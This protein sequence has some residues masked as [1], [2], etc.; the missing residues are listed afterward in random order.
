MSLQSQQQH[1]VTFSWNRIVRRFTTIW[2]LSNSGILLIHQLQTLQAL[3][4]FR[5]SFRWA[6]L[7]IHYSLAHLNEQNVLLISFVVFLNLL[8]NFSQTATAYIIFLPYISQIN[9]LVIIVLAKE[10]MQWRKW[11]LFGFIFNR[12]D[13][14]CDIS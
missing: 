3:L 5:S 9:F 6:M 13:V 2:L 1:V 10:K 7:S 4:I 14:K 11:T 12:A 8:N